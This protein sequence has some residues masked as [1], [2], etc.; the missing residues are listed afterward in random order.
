MAPNDY[1][2]NQCR[3][4]A[5]DPFEYD[6]QMDFL[7]MQGII[8]VYIPISSSDGNVMQ[9]QMYQNIEWNYDLKLWLWNMIQFA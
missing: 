4:G 1:Y 8:S 9:M 5:T 7:A 3:P 6:M 2:Q